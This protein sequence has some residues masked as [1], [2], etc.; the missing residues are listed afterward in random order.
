M[1][2]R[3]LESRILIPI[4]LFFWVLFL[5]PL[6]YYLFKKNVIYTQTKNK[7]SWIT[8]TLV[9]RDDGTRI[10][11]RKVPVP[12]SFVLS[13]ISFCYTGGGSETERELHSRVKCWRSS[14][15][16]ARRAL[17]TDCQRYHVLS[18]HQHDEGNY[19]YMPLFAPYRYF[20]YFSTNIHFYR[21]IRNEQIY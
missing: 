21:N 6:P 4:C 16:G 11:S 14:H 2:T 1:A 18:R 5:K 8:Q 13:C 10:T 20:S 12:A 3:K 19:T 15:Q 9:L 7:R 17:P